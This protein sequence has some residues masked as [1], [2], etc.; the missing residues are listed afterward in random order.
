ME[1]SLL[2]F[3]IVVVWI[4]LY[5]HITKMNAHTDSLKKDLSGLRKYIESQLE[6]L[7]KQQAATVSPKG[8]NEEKPMVKTVVGVVEEKIAV[9]PVE[10]FVEPAIEPL[11]EVPVSEITERQSPLVAEKQVVADKSDKPFTTSYL[12]G[13]KVVPEPVI[14]P[15]GIVE[16]K[17]QVDF[18]KYIGENLFGKIGILVLVVGMGLFVKYAIDQNWINEVFRTILGFV[19]GAGL[20]ILSQKLKNTYRTFSSLLAGGAF[21][22]FYVTVGIAYHYYG[23]FSQTSAFILLVVFTILMSVLSV[24]YDRRELAVIAL[25]GGF[26]APFLVS[27]GMGNYLVLF[28]Y[29]T[30]LNVGMFGLSLY[31]KWGE[32][33][34]ICFTATYVIMLGYSMVA[35]LDIAHS[36]QLVHLLL[37]STLFYMIFL[38]PIV[39]VMRT[40][41][42]N[43]SQLLVSIVV[44][45][46]FLYLFFALWY[47]HDLQLPYNIKG[48]FTLFIALVNLV[49]AFAVRKRKADKGLLFMLLTGMCL[50]F[51]SITIPIQLDGTFITLL[52]ATEMVVVLWLFIRF[53]QPVYAYFT[54]ALIGLTVISYLM[55]LENAIIHE[56]KGVLFMNG[57]FATGIFTGLAF[58]VF[59][60]LMERHK[61]FF[62]G[63]S[64]LPYMPFS[65][66]TLLTGC[67]IVYL[68]FIVD[69][70]INIEYSLLSDSTS[71]AFT[72]LTFLLLLVGLRRRFSMARFAV[73]YAIA[74]GISCY[75]FVQL[76]KYANGYESSYLLFLQW[77]TLVVMAVHLFLL[78]KFYYDSFDF[79]QKSSNLMTTFIAIVSTVVWA[80]AVNN[81]LHLT[82]LE[83]E[84]SAALSISLSIAGFIQ[85]SLGMRLHLKRLR[86]I[87]LGVFGL[88]LL[89]LVI[90]DLWLLPTVGKIIVFIMLGVIL[91]VLSFLYQKLKKVLFMEG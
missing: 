90:V 55:D 35:D 81:M 7:R 33:P 72:C 11:V 3:L 49:I 16:E 70:Y 52:W 2:V 65:A 82:G 42:K 88:V 44:L 63:A 83:Q 47:L 66:I 91:L 56:D 84:S 29:L 58:G 38:L 12:E 46:N 76:S 32:L 73:F 4:S 45:N 15:F 18:E 8:N 69:F 50:T 71:L 5:S 89:K 26:I 78:G 19:V 53:Q 24:L 9:K 74:T 22:I 30:I 54:L 86:M 57:L 62:M 27:N 77:G 80:V 41:E 67:V 85:M 48:A 17:K 34:V 23:L 25:I 21:A 20:L 79:R 1:T 10:I 68:T 51:I 14:K 40:E 13:K 43:I 28:T 6:E 31:K 60:W 37:F 64:K 75:L 61:S 87:S 39:S 59:V 36:S